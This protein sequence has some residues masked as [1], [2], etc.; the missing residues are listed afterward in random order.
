MEFGAT[1]SHTSHE[2][3]LQYWSSMPR[4]SN[5]WQMWDP[6]CGCTHV[7]LPIDTCLATVWTRE[8]RENFELTQHGFSYVLCY[9][10]VMHMDLSIPLPV[11]GFS[12]TARRAGYFRQIQ[13]DRLDQSP[14]NQHS[15][16]KPY[17]AV[18]R[19]IQSQ[20]QW[21]KISDLLR[22][23][24]GSTERRRHTKIKSNSHSEQ[25]RKHISRSK[26]GCC[27][28]TESRCLDLG[29][30]FRWARSLCAAATI[31]YLT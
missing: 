31:R 18:S 23:N 11:R 19:S 16:V 1:I 26:F 10:N 24:K 14:W 30:D 22:Q 13:T 9:L 27:R 20:R 21:S 4:Y 8:T 5:G 2:H 12:Q 28:S 7:L 29:S 25:D 6:G 15:K 17:K 3:N